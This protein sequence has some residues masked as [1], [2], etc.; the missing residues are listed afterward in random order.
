MHPCRSIRGLLAGAVALFML[1]V[2]AACNGGGPPDDNGSSTPDSV[3]YLTGFGA[4]AHDA[5]IFVADEKGFFADAGIDL[6]IE[7]GGGSANYAALLADEAQFTYI[8]FTG[9][10]VQMGRGDFEPGAFRA[11]A[12]V[13]QNTL[14]ALM[15]PESSDIDTPADLTGKRIGV[16]AG[17][18]TEFLLPAYANRSGWTHNPDLIVPVQVQELFGLLPAGRA[19]ALSTFIIQR[20][21][22][23]QVAGEPMVVFPMSEVLSDLLG[24]G[25]ISTASLADAN[26]ELVTRFRDAALR[27][28]Q[29]TIEH[30]EEAIQILSDRNP[31]AVT[32]PPA[33]VA[34]IQMMTPYVTAN[35]ADNVGVIDP[36]QVTR[37]I[38]VLEDA[39]LIPAGL[40]PEAIVG[41]QTLTESTQ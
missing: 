20:G 10:L 8:D 2:T 39:D 16:F 5:F 36:D 21:V 23:E 34:Q 17:S 12:S 18:P 30:P 19:D 27:G 1:T 22:I 26:P 11:L 24:T 7:L 4:S 31:G 33:Y 28:L 3:T 38:K 13:H 41:P 25:L 32:A 15:A 40:T 9:L 6:T 35:G 37:C 14:I 29:Y